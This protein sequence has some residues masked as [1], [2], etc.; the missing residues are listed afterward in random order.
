MPTVVIEGNLRFVI[1]TRE[2]LYEPPRVHV[3]F[4]GLSVCRIRL[5]DGEF[6]EEPPSGTAGRIMDAYLTN[7]DLIN[8][9]WYSI[10]KR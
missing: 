6:M 1:N 7:A 3:F 9:T 10:H 8:R 4:G 5:R 2:N